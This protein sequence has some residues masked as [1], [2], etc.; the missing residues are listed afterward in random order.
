MMIGTDIAAFMNFGHGAGFAKHWWPILPANL[1]VYT[2]LEELPAESQ[3]L[4]DYNPTLAKQMLA[5]AGYPDGFTIDYMFTPAIPMV[6]AT[7]LAALVKDQWAKIGVKVNLKPTEAITYTRARETRAYHGA[8]QV[9]CEVGNSAYII[10]SVARS[11]GV[12][13]FSNYSNKRIDELC[14]LIDAEMGPVKQ[15]PY[16]KEAGVIA[17]NEV[18]VVPLYMWP[19]GH[20]WWPW[21]KNYHGELSIA[22][23]YMDSVW[24]YIW[25]DQAMKAEMGYK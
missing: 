9:G 15:S 20:Y 16:I 14:G 21:V 22:D 3:L 1:D 13:N 2:P 4:Y 19:R 10:T 5:D 11:T 25:I 6:V 17:L 8:V 12:G 18:M 23:G 24:T 7:D